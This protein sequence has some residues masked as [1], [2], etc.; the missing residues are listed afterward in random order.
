[1]SKSG[2]NKRNTAESQEKVLTRY[3]LKMQRREAKKKKD[4]RDK[5]IASAV[6]ILLVVGLICLVA[7]FPIRSWNTVHGTYIVVG[8]ENVS[9][10]EFDYNYYIA[11]NQNGYYLSLFG[12]DTSG[13]LSTQMY[14][15]T[16]SWK[17]YFE[18]LAVE[19]LVRSKALE[20]EMKAN[21]FS[22]DADEEFRKYEET[23]RQAASE[24]GVSF[25]DYLKV[26]YGPYATLSRI[27]GF[28]KDGLAVG[29]YYDAIAEEKKPS[30]AEIQAYYDDDR[31][32]FDAVDYRVAIVEAELPTE[33]TELADPEAEAPEGEDAAYE[34]SDAEIQA[35]MIA[36]S[37]EA[38]S[39]EKTVMTR[40]D[41]LENMRKTSVSS[42]LRD[43]LFDDARKAGDTTVIDDMSGH[44]Y[45]VLGFVDR[46]LDQ[47]PTADVRI[48]IT[49]SENG[50]AVLDEWKA[51]EAT[52]E[53]FAALAD[54]YNGIEVSS[55]EGGLYE[56]LIPSGMAQELT[57]WIYDPARVGGETSVIFP[58]GEDRAYVVYYIGPNDP[59]WKLDIE[60]SL[61]QESMDAYTEE[62]TEGIE[63]EDPHNHLYYLEVRAMEEA[64]AAES[65]EAEDGSGTDDSSAE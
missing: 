14:S 16:M 37:V 44:Q 61:T 34:P 5:K 11:V 19:N 17:D 28:I 3:D 18:E 64:A 57:D 10:L 24:Q 40:G 2:K 8:G 7:S 53:S 49:E 56:A 1:M 45:Y 12:I 42:L 46:Y 65:G 47:S 4:A 23:L 29:A 6:G 22:Y 59:E 36:A 13:D 58:E 32:N 63:V 55:D 21:G 41:L 26:L 48:I 43:W 51:G 9:R 20:R 50:Q 31:S 52:E 54:Q 30:D 15:G 62:I 35:A 25:D 33:P 60:R 27:E 39:Q 38:E